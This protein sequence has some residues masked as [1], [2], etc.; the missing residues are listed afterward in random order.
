MSASLIVPRRHLLAGAAALAILAGVLGYGVARL[1]QDRNATAA[2]ETGRKILYWYDPMVP[3]Q[4]FDRPGKSPFM[5]MQLVPKYADGAEAA[6]AGIRIS[7]DRIQRLGMRYATVRR[8]PL[9][10]AMKVSGTV[11][12]NQRQLA[13]VQSRAAGF[14]QRVYAR[15]PGDIIAAGA[16]LADILVPEWGGAQNEYL[17]VRR[18][19]NS[20]LARAARQRLL[21]LGMSPSQVAAVER[22]GRVHDVVS[23]AAPAGGAIK[24]LGVRSGMTVG[25][26]QTLAEI[27][28]L[29]TVWLNA[30][31]P[32]AM[33]ARARV[34]GPVRAMFAA[35]PGEP[36][37]GRI[38]AILPET[39]ATSRTLTV[40]VE[41]PNPGLRLRPGMFA[42]VVL[43]GGDREALVVPSEAVIRTGRR[44]LVMLA[45]EGGRFLP[46]QVE[47]GRESGGLTE[48]VAGLREGERVVASGQFL[49]DSEASLSGV[50]VRP[51]SGSS[52]GSVTALH[53]SVGRV[54]TIERDGITIS[55]APV[56]AIGWP[57]MT[58]RF[59]V[60]DAS[61]IRGISPGMRVRF[62]FDHSSEG[63]VLRSVQPEAAR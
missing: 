39:E 13:I 17:A 31:V 27:N 47:T 48:I 38:T 2:A 28:G 36:F 12:F 11:E 19:G 50:A 56:P 3:S 22:S 57:A 18:T 6:E 62:A 21:L 55:H 60:P 37:A 15:A 16:P 40:R 26:G 45:R 33:A 52:T 20:A 54:E 61:V 8:E 14:V 4:H 34:G 59:R 32:E 35:F 43:S 5:D 53:R 24:A 29:G 63:P 46:A 42:T 49:I 10:D 23:I 30:A 25:A 9:N 1:L 51:L 7:P 58:M 44:S 41:L